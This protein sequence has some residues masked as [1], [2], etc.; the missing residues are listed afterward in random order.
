M[1]L[2]WLGLKQIVLSQTASHWLVS[3]FLVLF[4]AFSWL[5]LPNQKIGDYPVFNS[6]DETANYFFARRFAVNGSFKF[7]DIYAVASAGHILPRSMQLSFNM[8]APTGFIGLPLIYGFVAQLTSVSW[9]LLLTPVV[10]ALSLAVL[11]LALK[12]YYNHKIALLSV[13]FIGLQPGWMYSAVRPLMA[14]GLFMACVI[15]TLAFL[16]LTLKYNRVI[17]YTLTGVFTGLALLVRTSEAIWLLPLA[18]LMIVIFRKKLYW[19][20]LLVSF[21][22]TLPAVSLIG[23]YNY[24]NF[25]SAVQFGYNNVVAEPT[26]NFI[27][28]IIFPFGVDIAKSLQHLRQYTFELFPL[29]TFFTVIGL[30]VLINFVI[31]KKRKDYWLYLIGGLLLIG[32]LAVYYGSWTFFDNP[33]PKA[34]TI[35]NS[36]VRYY[37]PITI[38]TVPL[39]IFTLSQL[40]SFSTKIV[41]S[42]LMFSSLFFTSVSTVWLGKDEGVLKLKQTLAGYKLLRQ[43]IISQTS[44]NAIIVSNKMDK[45][46]FPFRRVVLEPVNWAIVSK[47]SFENNNFYFLSKSLSSDKII[48]MNNLLKDYSLVLADGKLLSNNFTLY[49]LIKDHEVYKKNN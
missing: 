2:N 11:Y 43:E 3:V 42:L 44:A 18:V 16:W 45:A 36:Y 49:Q 20:G 37:L 24:K 27:K 19:L 17:F 35:G 7:D 1:K 12:N 48:S 46:V 6:P 33:D 30:L 39:M 34:V 32:Y 47:Y 40:K 10:M 29:M 28:S 23:T 22:S 25:S 41:I 8:V 38:L 13:V 14:T 9:L 4:V 26:T 21:I 5:A 31:K 15:M